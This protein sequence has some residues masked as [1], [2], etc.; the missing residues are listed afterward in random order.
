[1]IRA[2]KHANMQLVK[3]SLSSPVVL[4]VILAGYLAVEMQGTNFTGRNKKAKALFNVFTIVKVKD[5][6]AYF[7]L[8]NFLISLVYLKKEGL[9]MDSLYKAL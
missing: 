4:V 8:C 7:G 5:L 6:M 2:E 9:L 3:M 1:M